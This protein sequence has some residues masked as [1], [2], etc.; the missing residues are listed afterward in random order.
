MDFTCTVHSTEVELWTILVTEWSVTTTFFLLE[1]VDRSLEL[2]IWLDFTWLTENHT[3]L[4]LVLVD[5][6]EEETYVITSLTLIEELTEHLNTCYSRVLILTE[7]E[8]LNWVTYMDNT[9]FDTTCS[10]CT[11]TSD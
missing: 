6:T 4:N 8:E 2:L 9:C 1:D 11:T 10:N 7:T 5:T 3:T